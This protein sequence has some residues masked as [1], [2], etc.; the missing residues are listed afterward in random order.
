MRL[1]LL[2]GNVQYDGMARDFVVYHHPQLHYALAAEGMRFCLLARY[3][4]IFDFI[5]SFSSR[6]TLGPM[7]EGLIWRG[8]ASVYLRLYMRNS[9]TAI[10]ARTLPATSIYN[11]HFPVLQYTHCATSRKRSNPPQRR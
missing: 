4:L 6:I 10:L 2:T 7:G 1:N 11:L 8:L 3:H 5:Y 9:G